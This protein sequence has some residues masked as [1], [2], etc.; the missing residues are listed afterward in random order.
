MVPLSDEGGYKVQLTF[1][2]HDEKMLTIALTGKV[3]T[4][5]QQ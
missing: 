5:A 1:V 3:P 2:L 4:K